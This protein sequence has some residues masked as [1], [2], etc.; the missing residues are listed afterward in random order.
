M[1]SLAVDKRPFKNLRWYIAVM[2]CVSSELN[3]LDRQTLSVL[4]DTIQRELNLTTTG[5]SVSWGLSVTWPRRK[6]SKACRNLCG[7]ESRT[8]YVRV[9]DLRLKV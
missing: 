1:K 4:A 5:S 2:L 9:P 6:T 3:Y 8:G 7:L